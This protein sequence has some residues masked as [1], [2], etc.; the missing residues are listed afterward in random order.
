[1]E[2]VTLSPNIAGEELDPKEKRKFWE[3]HIKAWRESGVTQAEYCR[4]NNLK[5]HRW[6]YWRKRISHSADPDIKF[7]PLQFPSGK[8]SRHGVNVIT[9]NGYRIEIDH[10]FDLSKLR[11]LISAVRGL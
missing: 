8:I 4:R 5:N 11:Q 9:P 2:E 1:M 7:V 3:N 10:G 6:W